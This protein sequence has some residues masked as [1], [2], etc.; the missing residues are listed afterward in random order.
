V[1]SQPYQQWYGLKFSTAQ[2][3][4]PVDFPV[5]DPH[6]RI[7]PELEFYSSRNYML[8]AVVSRGLNFIIV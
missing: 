7:L 1:E 2:Y 6:T 5:Y 4:V 8:F 3:G